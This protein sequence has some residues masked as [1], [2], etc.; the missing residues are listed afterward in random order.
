MISFLASPKTFTG[1]AVAQQTAAVRSWLAV[2]TG[3][4]VILYG[5]SPGTA[6]CCRELG[7]CHVPDIASSKR[8]IPYFGA[9]AAHAAEH[10][11]HDLQVYLNCDILLTPHILKAIKRVQLSNFLMIGQRIDLTDGVAIDVDSP[12][13]V[14]QLKELGNDGR[15]NLHPH[16]GADYFAFRRGMWKELPPVIIGR[17]GYDNALIAFCLQRRIPIVDATLAILAIHQFHDYGHLDGGATEVFRGEDAKTNLEFVPKDAVPNMENADFILRGER[18]E[19]NWSR[20]DWLWHIFLHCR[21]RKLLLLPSLLKLLWRIQVKLGL[22]HKWKP[23]LE[24]VLANT[25]LNN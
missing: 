16:N 24:E 19:P 10:A 15:I 20:G 21:Y 11:Q 22:R 25:F 12:D 9:I 14:N 2:E 1:R 17:G 5:D 18:V 6:A 13:L 3:V 7:I 23:G 8:G 4:E